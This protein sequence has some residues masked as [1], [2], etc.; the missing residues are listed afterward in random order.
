LI[1]AFLIR[2]IFQ[3]IR[4]YDITLQDVTKPWTM[5]P[6]NGLFLQDD[7]WVKIQKRT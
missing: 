2:I 5:R 7:M 1:F 3:L 6:A 4:R